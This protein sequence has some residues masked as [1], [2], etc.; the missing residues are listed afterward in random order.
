LEVIS[1]AHKKVDAIS[2]NAFD[3]GDTSFRLNVHHPTHAL[4]V[5]AAD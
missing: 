1:H 4:G 2:Q 5:A 3:V